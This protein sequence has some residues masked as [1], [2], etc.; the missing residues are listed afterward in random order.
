MKIVH[1]CTQDFGGAGKAAYRL[2][3]GLNAIGIDSKMVVMSKN[4]GDY[5]V[6]VLPET[7]Q[8]NIFNCVAVD[9]HRSQMFFQQWQNWTAMLNDYPN[10]PQGLEM[11]SDATALSKL[12]NCL[13][14]KEADIINL[15]WVA[16]IVD[17]ETMKRAFGSKPIIWTLH[18]M[19]PFTGGCHYAGDCKNYLSKCS[20]CEQLGS[21]YENDASSIIWNT[22]NSAY[23]NLDI[24][25]V[26]PSKWLGECA[27]ESSLFSSRDV[28]IIPYGFPLEKFK[29]YET[30]ELKTK[31]GISENTQLVLF[32]A[33]SVTN[34]RK[35]FPY[36]LE[37]LKQ[38]QVEP[39]WEIKLG[40]FGN[41][42]DEIKIES[43]FEIIRF[44]SFSDEVE[45]AKIYS[46]ADV[47]VIPSL[48]DNL[49]N[50]VVESM[51]CGTPVVG[52]NIGG[53]PDMIS[54]LKTGYLAEKKN[55]KDLALGITTVLF[56]LNADELS[57][58]CLENAR[59]NYPL[60]LQASRYAE[61]YTKILS[62]KYIVKN[63]L[64]DI[65]KAEELIEA[66]KYDDAK[67]ILLSL[68]EDNNESVVALN[69][70]AV[71]N[72]LENNFS[73][74]ETYI[75]SVLLID[76]QNSIAH[77][78]LNFI[79][80]QKSAGDEN[81]E[82]PKITIV[83][84]SYNQAEFL[85][86]TIKSVLSQGYPNLEYIIMDGG[87][88]DGS[89]EI[90]KKYEDQLAYWQSKP[91]GG[92]Y[93]AIEEGLNRG[94]GEIMGWI[95]SDDR[96]YPQSLQTVASI[97]M[98][99]N[100]IEWITGRPSMF[101][102]MGEQFYRIDLSVWSQERYLKKNYQ[103]IQQECTFWKKV[104]WEKAGS[105]LRSELKLAG[106]L[107]LWT[108]FFRHAYLHS[109]DILL[110]GFRK[111]PNQKT[112]SFMNEYLK[113]AENILDAEIDF[114]N[115]TGKT[116]KG[117]V[118]LIKLNENSIRK[119]GSKEELVSLVD[120]VDKCIEE[121]KIKYA[122]SNLKKALV[123][124]PNAYHLIEVLSDLEYKNGN[125]T[126]SKILLWNLIERFNAEE[127][128]FDKLLK[129][130]MEEFRIDNAF[131]LLKVYKSSFSLN[132]YQTEYDKLDSQLK[133][134]RAFTKLFQ[135]DK[136]GR[137]REALSNLEA[138]QNKLYYNFGGSEISSNG[139]IDISFEELLAIAPRVV[140][141]IDN[142][143]MQELKVFLEEIVQNKINNPTTE[144]FVQHN[145]LSA[146]IPNREILVSAIVSTYNSEKFIKGCLDDL[147]SQTIYKKGLLEIVVVNSGSEENEDDIIE[148]Y[149]TRSSNI[150]YIKTNERETIY[151]AW[152]RGIKAAKGKFI[153]NANTDDRHRPDAYEKMINQFQS[154]K[155]IDLVYADVLQTT[156]PN[157]DYYSSSKKSQLNWIDF[158]ADLLL[159]GCY[160]G[161]QPMWKKELHDKFGYFDESLKVV[162]DYEFWLRISREANFHHIQETLGLYLYAEDSA[163]HRDNSLT[164]QENDRVKTKYICKYIKNDEMYS[165]VLN[166]LN[167]INKIFK[168]ELYFTSNSIFLKKR[169][170]GIHLERKIFEFSQN[171]GAGTNGN[172]DSIIQTLI[173]L[174]N[175]ENAIVDKDFYLGVLYG[176]RGSY[177]LTLGD[178]ESARIHFESS[179]NYDSES[180]D[181]CAGLGE[182][183]YQSGI[184]NTAE[185][186]FEWAMKLDTKNQ[187]AEKRLQK[188]N[189]EN[190]MQNTNMSTDKSGHFQ[191][192]E[193][194]ESL[195]NTEKYNDARL[196]LNEILN[197]DNKHV[198]AL[199]DLSVIEILEGNFYRAAE[200]IS[201]IID[202]DPQN[203]VA[204]DNLLNLEKI[205][206]ENL[207]TIQNKL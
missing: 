99:D 174:V 111:Q 190:N 103:F 93:A 115:Q 204:K 70:L 183:F 68:L 185:E 130:E 61:L 11:F 51:A 140:D 45:I 197:E 16:G 97:F 150:T 32:G 160:I 54:H 123:I 186:M 198:D 124:E 26:T 4:S 33:E 131:R 6:K 83:T 57:K 194:A 50:T 82:F 164:E 56:K 166:K 58:N 105:K 121:N 129:Y 202:I 38:I 104:L 128:V 15:H 9:V 108:R 116:P 162:G 34:M 96:L 143:K 22:K 1:I 175:D 125:T 8:E 37:S 119:F 122:I 178:L 20:N 184:Y 35:G 203:E 156:I 207:I 179:L 113:E 69:D 193:R 14:I 201:K 173:N 92:Q 55:I 137:A 71:I 47:F 195:I 101:N 158:D 2:N 86:E 74:A 77:E 84:P 135:L 39:G 85:E 36:L 102:N 100:S 145:T 132:K 153:T 42:P 189:R 53:I 114:I 28:Q 94:T 159:F 30:K 177:Y 118:P 120:S 170:N 44:G 78:N 72:I 138:F 40:I 10:K 91:D 80:Q 98:N 87:S 109:V 141:L 5:S 62:S 169:K 152:N 196:I 7:G 171:F 144:N 17:Y 52:F 163:E 142:L 200:M 151:E 76:P 192:I 60:K 167:E 48:E 75:N 21:D 19:N 165:V 117:K 27:K 41:L 155:N 90:I 149:K 95:N 181:A 146:E 88:T 49:P 172:T 18:D 157:D 168:H 24:N 205:V 188:I 126:D 176:L 3:L 89:V 31:Y 59:Q 46:L 147:T 81:Q 180:S 199:N 106:D 154:D 23:Q 25:I 133:T 65:H 187:F 206:D 73:K 43:K 29:P 161:P 67:K 134:C 107:E 136:V 127:E 64:A 79:I 191:N 139:K 12:E 112:A 66:G 110:G 148:Q 63:E 182:V 13:E